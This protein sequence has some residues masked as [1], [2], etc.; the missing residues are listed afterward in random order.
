MICW[1]VWVG[2][3]VCVVLFVVLFVCVVDCVLWCDCD[4]C[5]CGMIVMFCCDWMCVGVWLM[6]VVW[7]DFYWKCVVVWW[8]VMWWWWWCDVMVL[9][10]WW[11]VWC[12]VVWCVV[13]WWWCEVWVRWDVRMCEGWCGCF[14]WWCVASGMRSSSRM[15]VVSWWCDVWWCCGCDRWCLG[16]NCCGWGS[17]IK[18]WVLCGMNV[19][20]WIC[21][22]CCRRRCSIRACRSSVWLSVCVGWWMMLKNMCGLC[23]CMNEMSGCFIV[24]WRIIWRSCCR[25]YRRRR[26]GKCASSLVWCIDDCVGCIFLLKIV[27]LCIGCWKIGL[28]VMLRWLCLWMGNALRDSAIWAFKVWVRRW[29]S[30]CYLL[31][32]VVLIWW[33]CC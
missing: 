9:C 29:V 7:C 25:F 2:I 6:D 17:I 30:W 16:W 23:C 3:F 8:C 15:C 4:V 19:I 14:V 28:C 33:M 32:L 26:F 1:L 24:W 22:G 27:G 13:W 5:V 20:G 21:A 11:C 12:E 10:G 31:C 18:G